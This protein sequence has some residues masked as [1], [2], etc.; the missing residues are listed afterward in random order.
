VKDSADHPFG[1]HC[2]LLFTGQLKRGIIGLTKEEALQIVKNDY[3]SYAPTPV[4]VTFLNAKYEDVY[5]LYTDQ[6]YRRLVY[7]M[8]VETE[9]RSF[10]IFF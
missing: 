8:Q 1:L 5:D 9:E 3:E 7:R 10:N 4:R 2:L 6:D